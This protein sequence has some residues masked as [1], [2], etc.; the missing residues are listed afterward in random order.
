MTIKEDNY[1]SFDFLPPAKHSE[2]TCQQPLALIYFLEQLKLERRAF[3]PSRKADF[4]AYFAGTSRP[5][6]PTTQARAEPF[7][8]RRVIR[9]G[10]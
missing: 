3:V 7:D 6:P 9:S 5:Q 2:R 8:K 10:G 1:I 4:F